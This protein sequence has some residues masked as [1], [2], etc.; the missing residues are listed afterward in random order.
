M[1]ATFAAA[2]LQLDLAQSRAVERLHKAGASVR[3]ERSERTGHEIW[4]DFDR[5]VSD[6]GLAPL[7]GLRGLTVLRILGGGFGDAGVAHIAD[8]PDLWLLVLKSER[9]GEKGIRSITRIATLKKLDLIGPTLSRKSLIA[10]AG[11]PRLEQL[12]L[13][14][15]GVKDA[16]LEVLSGLTTLRTLVLPGTV[17]EAAVTSLRRRL[18]KASIERLPSDGGPVLLVFSTPGT[19]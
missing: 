10:I 17:G 13:Y 15:A 7:R 1:I 5:R 18:P 19:R 11:L 3:I 16:D 2:T 14:G 6:A 8:V 4:V 12:F 9:I